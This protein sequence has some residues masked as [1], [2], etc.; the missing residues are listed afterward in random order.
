MKS[1]K[2]R[3]CKAIT[4][5]ALIVTIIVLLIL[6]G[7][8]LA[9]V[10]TNDGIIERAEDARSAEIYGTDLETITVVVSEQDMT[11]L[12]NDVIRD[13][14]KLDTELEKKYGTDN[15]EVESVTGY[16]NE[17]IVTINKDEDRVYRVYDD[18]T[19]TKWEGNYADTDTD[20][21][22]GTDTDTDTGTDTGTD[23]DTDTGTGTETPELATCN[24]DIDIQFVFDIV[25]QPMDYT[26]ITLTVTGS[27]G[28]SKAMALGNDSPDFQYLTAEETG[29]YVTYRMKEPIEIIKNMQYTVE[30]K[31]AGYRTFR[32]TVNVENDTKVTLWDTVKNEAAPIYEGATKTYNVT[33]LAGDIYMDGLVDNTDQGYVSSWYGKTPVVGKISHA[34]DIDR[35]GSITTYDIAIVQITY[36]D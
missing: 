18:G 15:V 9:M 24:L 19:V 5:I 36:G 34:C 32:G 26:A 8:T 13:G 7:I 31:G 20:T 22:T 27:N 35:S 29:D 11:M 25:S 6:A 16:E 17:F 12:R 4:L 30:I 10:L 33:F 28:Y 14:T 21:D 1:T 2:L 3:E 23:T